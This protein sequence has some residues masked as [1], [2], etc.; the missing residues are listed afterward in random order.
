LAQ[1]KHHTQVRRNG[2]ERGGVVTGRRGGG[3]QKVVACDW[4]SNQEIVQKWDLCIGF[5]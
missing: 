2:E 5:D 3:S 4:L 1:R